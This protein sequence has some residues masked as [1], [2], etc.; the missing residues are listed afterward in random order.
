MSTARQ[1][2]GLA[3]LIFVCVQATWAQDIQVSRANK[4]VEVTV[5]ETVQVE[6]EVAVLSIGYQNYG[7]TKDACFEESVRAANRII[8]ALQKSN[9][10]KQDIETQELRV[11]HI[12][13][14]EKWS[15][16]MKTARQYAAK[17][18][19]SVRV[20][21]A[22]AQ[23]ILDLAV[24]AG[25]NDI[26]D[27]EWSVKDPEALEGKA[28]GAAL[29]KA[30]ALAA[31]MTMEFGSKLGELLYASNTLRR[32]KGWPFASG[33]Q[34]SMAMVGRKEIPLRLFPKKVE[35]QATVHAVFA[36]E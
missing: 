7:R 10:G 36:I 5:T 16:E 27:V 15:Q 19:W 31:R 20:P 34:T 14:D 29:A 3:V 26:D 8:D 24:R 9:V 2:A 11:Q 21:V 6:P 22:Q 4:T 13:P 28:T 32:P 30:R 17:Q 23:E 12:E 35:Q 25:A 1:I 18:A 33:L